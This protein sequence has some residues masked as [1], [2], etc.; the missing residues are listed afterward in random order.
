MS[1]PQV[2]QARVIAEGSLMNVYARHV[3]W[4]GVGG[5]RGWEFGFVD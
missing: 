4:V 1:A 2:S 5:C 3:V